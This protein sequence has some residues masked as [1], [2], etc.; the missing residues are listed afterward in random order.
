MARQRTLVKLAVGTAVLAVLAFLFLRSLESTRAAPFT[1]DR[2]ALTGWTLV[3]EPPMD[4]LGS[5]LALGPPPQLMASLGREIFRRGGES[6]NYPNPALMPL[7]L[8]DEF[9]RAFAGRV[10]P[11][12]IVTLARSAALESMTWTPRCMAHRRLSEPGRTTGVYFVLLDAAPFDE[13]RQRLSGLLQTVGGDASLFD[14]AAL[15]PALIVAALDGN[16]G[17]WMPL[18]GDPEADCMAPVEVS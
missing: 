16:F 3:L 6:V 10:P 1:V 13:L 11:E 5:W 2:G 8:Q 14:P 12:Q 18:R 9:D 7:L 17:R 4:P 15:S